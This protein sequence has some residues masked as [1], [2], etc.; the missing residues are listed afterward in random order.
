MADNQFTKCALMHARK[1]ARLRQGCGGLRP[2]YG[3]PS[4]DKQVRALLS[5]RIADAR[6]GTKG[7]T[8]ETI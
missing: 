1:L 4:A 2:A 5:G 7:L 3:Q 6:R 8:P